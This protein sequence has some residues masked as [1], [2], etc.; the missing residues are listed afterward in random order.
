MEFYIARKEDINLKSIPKNLELKIVSFDKAVLNKYEND[1][2]YS[3]KLDEGAGVLS[4]NGWDLQIDVGENRVSTFL[5]K[6]AQLPEDEIKNFQDKSIYPKE[7]GQA[8]YR[9]WTQGM[10]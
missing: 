1:N 6:L 10:P 8:A 3:I 4:G 9:R 2:K 7:L 5:Y